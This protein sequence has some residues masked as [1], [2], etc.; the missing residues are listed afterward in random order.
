M[1]RVR[2]ALLASLAS[3]IVGFGPTVEPAAAVPVGPF[4][5]GWQV[6]WKPDGS[7]YLCSFVDN[8]S[9]TKLDST[10]WVVQTSA[11]PSGF[12]AGGT[13]YVDSPANVFVWGGRLNLMGRVAPTASECKT[14]FKTFRTRYT[15][16]AVVSWEKFAQAYGR[17]SFRARFP[18]T[19]Q[20]GYYGNLW[21]YPQ[22]HTYGPW[23]LSGEID[24]AEQWSG[25]V[26]RAFPSLHFGG[27]TKA[28]TA[29][30]CKVANIGNFHI[31]TLEWTPTEM[32]FY[33]DTTLC[34]RRSW[35]PMAPFAAPQPFDQP[36][37]LVMSQGLGPDGFNTITDALPKSGAMQVDWVRVWR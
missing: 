9:G 24:I 28:D 32:K 19:H 35:T 34:F 21:M 36:F 18:A 33:Y 7:R 17:F 26:D 5:C 27:R 22:R 11:G 23:P 3:V 16:G 20:P 12:V 1:G 15:G 25:Y 31:Y 14:P 30:N 10:K 6:F 2:V 29:M 4:A 8:F 13:C 37:A